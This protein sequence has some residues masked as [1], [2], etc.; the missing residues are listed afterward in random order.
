[1]QDF[2]PSPHGGNVWPRE[3]GIIGTTRQTIASAVHAIRS[4]WLA[5]VRHQCPRT[6]RLAIEAD[7][8][9][10]NGNR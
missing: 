1:M 10:A 4:W 7:S 5:V 2:T 9:S 3:Y 6:S 8:G